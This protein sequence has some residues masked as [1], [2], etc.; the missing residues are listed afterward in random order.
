MNWVS[1]PRSRSHL[2]AW[3]VVCLFAGVGFAVV[4]IFALIAWEVFNAF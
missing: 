2:P 3:Y 4:F 1:E